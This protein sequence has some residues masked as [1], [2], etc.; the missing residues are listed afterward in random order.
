MK[1]LIALASLLVLQG[2]LVWIVPKIAEKSKKHLSSGKVLPGDDELVLLCIDQLITGYNEDELEELADIAISHFKD[3]VKAERCQ[4][5]D[6]LRRI[7]IASD[8]KR[9]IAY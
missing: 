2:L 8:E 4:W 9:G 5:E 1:F 3:E 7:Y 6:F